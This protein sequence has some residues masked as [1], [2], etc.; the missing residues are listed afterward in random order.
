VNHLA[1]V[2]ADNIV[3]HAIKSST[4]DDHSDSFLR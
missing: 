1:G 4:I 2:E 3:I